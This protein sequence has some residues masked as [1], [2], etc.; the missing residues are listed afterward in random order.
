MTG[1]IVLLGGITL[2]A[3]TITVLD[4]ISYRREKAAKSR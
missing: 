1:L 2:I 3:V 4:G